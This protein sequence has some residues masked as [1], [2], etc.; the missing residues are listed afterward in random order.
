MTAQTFLRFICEGKE[1]T[2]NCYILHSRIINETLN[3]FGKTETLSILYASYKI[4]KEMELA[5]D[6]HIKSSTG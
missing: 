4:Y 6:V 3:K 2:Q 5:H 1:T